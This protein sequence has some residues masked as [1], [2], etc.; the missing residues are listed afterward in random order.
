MDNYFSMPKVTAA[1]Q[2][3]GIDIVGLAK[4]QHGWPAVCLKQVKDTN[5]HCNDFFTID[6]FGTL[7]ACRMDNI[8]IFCVFTAQKAG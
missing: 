2:E 8:M 5:A 7:V 3:L 6:K 1:L 4:Y